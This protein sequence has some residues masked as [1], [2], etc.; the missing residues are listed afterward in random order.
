MNFTV[1]IKWVLL[2]LC[3]FSFFAIAYVKDTLTQTFLYLALTIAF[4]F[5]LVFILWNI[6]EIK[7]IT[8]NNKF[9]I[10]LPLLSCFLV[11]NGALRV[12]ILF[13]SLPTPEV[14]SILYQV[15]FFILCALMVL[16]IIK[17]PSS[18][19]GVITVDDRP[20]KKKWVNLISLYS[21]NSLPR[22][23]QTNYV[24]RKIFDNQIISEQKFIAQVNFSSMFFEK[25]RDKPTVH[26]NNIIEVIQ[27]QT[28]GMVGIKSFNKPT[29]LPKSNYS[30][31]AEATI[32]VENVST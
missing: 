14:Y 22:E 28:E 23:C 4:S 25:I 12:V 21:L 31:Y 7:L 5:L 18:S 17:T 11:A 27:T 3:I 13:I 1:K 15:S 6:E 30:Y 2:T 26:I 20:I 32:T 29:K 16:P 8:K 9:I 24:V 19:E 10:L